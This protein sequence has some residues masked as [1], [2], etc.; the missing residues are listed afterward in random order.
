[1][2]F[3]FLQTINLMSQQIF[4]FLLTYGIR[5]THH[6]VA[7]AKESWN[8]LT[9]AVLYYCSPMYVWDTES[10]GLRL[11]FALSVRVCCWCFRGASVVLES[12]LT[13]LC[14]P[15]LQLPTTDSVPVSRYSQCSAGTSLHAVHEQLQLPLATPHAHRCSSGHRS[16]VDRLIHTPSLAQPSG[17]ES[18]SSDGGRGRTEVSVWSRGGGVRCREEEIPWLT[19]SWS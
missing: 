6:F 19:I 18:T 13:Y 11:L 17:S 10:E 3:T 2:Y 1:M 12:L 8:Q 7:S 9:G 14:S 16:R 15:F 4:F 5:F